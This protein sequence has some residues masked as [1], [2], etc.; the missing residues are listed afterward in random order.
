MMKRLLVVGL[1]LAVA[2]CAAAPGGP[3]PLLQAQTG[4]T[5][6]ELVSALGTPDRISSDGA[7]TTV[8]YD[9]DYQWISHGVDFWWR[10]DGTDIRMASCETRFN[11]NNGIV[12]GYEVQGR[13]C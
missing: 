10:Y 4:K 11:M 6:A 2:G 1:V 8:V 7:L 12:D 13:N 9:H 5:Q 3:D